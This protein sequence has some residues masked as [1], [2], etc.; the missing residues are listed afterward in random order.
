MRTNLSYREALSIARSVHGPLGGES[1]PLDRAHGRRCAA[2]FVAPFDLPGF[3]NAA[4]DGYAVR[5]EDLAGEGEGEDDREKRFKL[6]ARILAGDTSQHE[7][8]PGQAAAIMTGAMLPRHADTVVI[9]E[10]ARVE[11][12]DVWLPADARRGAHVRAADDDCAQGNDILHRSDVLTAARLAQLAAFGIEDIEV[13]KR[14]RVAILVTGDELIS[15]GRP[16]LSGQRY[17]SNGILLATMAEAGGAHVVACERCGDNPEALGDVVHRLSAACDMLVTSGGVSAGDA[18]HLPAV[19][20]RLGD[21]AFWK[22]RIKPGMP[23]LCGRIDECVVFAL[24]GNPVSAGVT[25]QVLAQPALDAM[26]SLPASEAT[27]TRA[28]LAVNW[29]KTHARLEFLRVRLECDAFGGLI[30]TP[31]DRQGSGTLSVLAHADALALLPE[32]PGDFDAG[33]VVEVLDIRHPASRRLSE[34]S[35]GRQ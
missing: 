25:F 6:V 29:R 9:R 20:A 32:G 15:P 1:L 17:D 23:V 24:P 7:L 18:D 33:T 8:A 19:V 31:F 16:L 21:I 2:D 26:Q 35:R 3:A 11:G 12:E 4:M 13:I 27:G 30:A 10:N 22:A 5:G 28:R 34:Y 14:P